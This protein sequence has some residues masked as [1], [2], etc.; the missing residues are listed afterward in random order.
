M[1]AAQ[2][3]ALALVI[4]VQ[5]RIG[6]PGADPDTEGPVSL[7]TASSGP[8]QQRGAETEAGIPAGYDEPVNVDGRL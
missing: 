3:E 7:A 6:G 4:A 2:G 1:E 5:A 8:V